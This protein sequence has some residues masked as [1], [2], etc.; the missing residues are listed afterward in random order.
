MFEAVD[1][2]TRT[3]LAH[4]TLASTTKSGSMESFW[5]GE[6]LKYFY[7]VFSDGGLVSLD[8]YVFDTE[9]HPFRRLVR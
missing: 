9:A 5:L 6:T 7:L 8:E 4:V 3:A 1:G 2:R